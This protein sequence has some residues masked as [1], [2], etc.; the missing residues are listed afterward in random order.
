MPDTHAEAAAAAARAKDRQAKK[1]ARRVPPRVGR[2][3][4]AVGMEDIEGMAGEFAEA[5]TPPTS[6]QEGLAGARRSATDPMEAEYSDY[7]ENPCN[8]A[9]GEQAAADEVVVLRRL[10]RD[11]GMTI[12]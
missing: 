6:Q 4:L 11:P 9:T 2:V 10:T 1:K 12:L 3:L 7:E 8:V 5:G